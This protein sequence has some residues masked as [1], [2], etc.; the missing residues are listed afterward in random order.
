MGFSSGEKEKY[1]MDNGKTIEEMVTV[2][3]DF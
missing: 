1:I 3:R 2:I